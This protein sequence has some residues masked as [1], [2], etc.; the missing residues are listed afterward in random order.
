M[1]FRVSLIFSAALGLASLPAL[2]AAPAAQDDLK[3]VLDKLNVAAANF[4]SAE[5]SVEYDTIETDPVPDTDIQKGTFDFERKG[6]SV[7]TG[8]HF[9]EHDGKPSAKAYTYAGGVFKLFEP[10]INQVT[11]HA[12]AGKYESYIILGFGASGSELAAKWDINYQGAEMLSDGKAM[13]KTARLELVAKDPAV[14]KTIPK[15][16]IWVDPD[17]AVSLKQV[18]T[19]SSTSTWVCTYSNIKLNSSLPSDAFTFKTNSKTVIQN[20]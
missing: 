19:L 20:Q 12:G 18:F 1:R 6:S 13:V 3:S 9:T 11:V 10:S 14:R 15:V 4:H 16:V 8:V 5:A 17:R 7:R 2:A